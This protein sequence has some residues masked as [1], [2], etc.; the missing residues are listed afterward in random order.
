[1][2]VFSFLLF[3]LSVDD[4][5]RLVGVC[6]SQSKPRHKDL[7]KQMSV[8]KSLK[9]QRHLPYKIIGLFQWLAAEIYDRKPRH[10]YL[11]FLSQQWV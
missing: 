1:V 7:L 2:Y 5:E 8:T 9:R 6:Q 10:S 4:G 3:I 11:K